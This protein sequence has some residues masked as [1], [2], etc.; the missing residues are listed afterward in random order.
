MLTRIECATH[1]DVYRVTDAK[2]GL[3]GVIAIHS[4]AAGPAAG[5][6]R[7][8]VYGGF[9]EALQ[10]ALNL[11]RGMSF[12]N[13]AA[14][15]PLGGGKSVI[16][17]DPAT[18]KTPELLRA[19]GR[20]VGSLQGRYWTA[21]DMGMTPDDMRI[22]RTQTQY[23]AGLNDGEFASGDPSPITA[24]GVFRAI[25]VGAAHV[26]G[27]G[28]LSGRSVAVQGLGHVGWHLC[29]HLYRAGARLIVADVAQD[30]ANRAV[31]TFGAS[32]VAPDVITRAEADIFAPCAIGGILTADNARHIK[33]RLICGAANNQLA[34][35]ETAEALATADVVYLPDYVA[36]AGGIINVGTEIL[37]IRDREGF[38]RDKLAH[39]ERTMSD[40][41]HQAERE[42]ISP[43]RIADRVV[44]PRTLARAS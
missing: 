6:L 43:A 42:A 12:K 30:Q 39:L 16:L 44:A 14:G 18:D 9:E 23:V 28:D 10:D 7:M 31:A 2:A 34:S 8:R 13:A 1:E 33:A 40:I 38:V 20:A 3:D 36:N 5:G 25:K 41:L 32:V 27:S 17:G 11:S 35:P 24:E 19:M 4:T 21:E 29:E 15:L 26:F 22:L 37:R